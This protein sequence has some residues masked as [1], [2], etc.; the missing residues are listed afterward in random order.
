MSSLSENFKER[1]SKFYG[2][3]RISTNIS[4]ALKY[5]KIYIEL[6]NHKVPLLKNQERKRKIQTLGTLK[7]GI[8]ISGV[9]F[10]LMYTKIGILNR[11]LIGLI[12]TN[13]CTFATKG[14]FYSRVI[15]DASQELSLVGQETRIQLRYHFTDHPND[16]IFGDLNKEYL[17]LSEKHS[18]KIEQYRSKIMK[19]KMKDEDFIEK[20][21]KSQ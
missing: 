14:Y 8:M 18:N 7:S 2:S 1:L 5:Q 15:E 21:K 11:M 20:L 6:L 12:A 10:F 17:K 9:C 3:L 13:I 19:E 4:S 16:S